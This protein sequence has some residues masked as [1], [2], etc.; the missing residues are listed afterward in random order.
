[1]SMEL[2]RLETTK[3]PFLLPPRFDEDC[4]TPYGFFMYD[5]GGLGDG[6]EYGCTTSPPPPS[7]LPCEVMETRTLSCKPMYVMWSVAMGCP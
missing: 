1:M 3:P 4:W 2:G 5:D 6:V 7:R